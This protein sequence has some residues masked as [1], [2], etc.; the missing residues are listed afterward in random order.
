MTKLLPL[1]V[2]LFAGIV[3]PG[4]AQGQPTQDQPA[5]EESPGRFDIGASY[6]GAFPSASTGD[7]VHQGATASGGVLATFRWL[8]NAHNG[9]EFDYGYTRDTGQF[10]IYNA[11]HAVH[12]DMQEG[13]ASYVFHAAISPHAGV[14]VSAGGGALVF[15]PLLSGALAPVAPHT[16]AR[17]T[18]VYAAGMEFA[19]TQHF[20]LRPEYRAFV[21]KA[22]SF[23]TGLGADAGMYIPEMVAGFVWKL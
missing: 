22:P 14:F 21:L 3:E 5:Q 2:L 11:S 6:L 13:T 1:P 9:I 23:G 18:F 12:T 16:Q 15:D 20:M 19:I 8:L 17:A 4:F 7:G 10:L